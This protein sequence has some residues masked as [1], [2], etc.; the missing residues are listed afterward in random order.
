V[1]QEYT[2]KFDPDAAKDLAKLPAEISRRIFKKIQDSKTDPLHYW[3]R[4]DGRTDH[5]LRIGDY[6]AIAD[7]YSKESLIHITKIGHRKNM[8]ENR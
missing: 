5:R 6:R 1:K 4:L 8:Y 3:L 7:I 2:L